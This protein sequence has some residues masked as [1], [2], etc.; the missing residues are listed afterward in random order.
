[1]Q[2]AEETVKLTYFLKKRR[3]QDGFHRQLFMQHSLES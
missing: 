2:T 1:M 3:L